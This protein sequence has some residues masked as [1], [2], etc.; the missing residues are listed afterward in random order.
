MTSFQVGSL[1]NI[2]DNMVRYYCGYIQVQAPG[3]FENRSIN[4]GFPMNPDL[5]S[6]LDGTEHVSCY[7]FRL[8]AFA[9]VS[10]GTISQGAMVMGIDPSREDSITGISKRIKVGQYLS[11]DDKGILVG[12]VLA[13]NLGAACGDTLILLGQGYHGVTAAALF[14]IRGILRFPSPEI[15]RQF[16]IMELHTAQEFYSADQIVTSAVVLLDN[17]DNMVKTKNRLTARLGT[18]YH[19]L[20]WQELQP[21]LVQLVDGKRSAGKML[22]SILFLIIGFGML[23]TVIMMVTERK[24]E[25]GV[26]IS[27]GM[28]KMRVFLVLLFEAIWVGILGVAAGLVIGYPLITQLAVHPFHLTGTMAK[29]MVDMGFE[30]VLAISNVGY[31]FLNPAVTVFILSLLVSILPAIIV[32]RMKIVNALRA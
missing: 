22:L 31:V 27:L 3:Y 26:M 19:V 12:E 21:G 18:D 11:P 7:T 4:E 17:M 15:S 14:P 13:D 5:G 23:G 28:R 16:I 6:V 10:S 8:E 20:D 25:M 1:Q 30:P 32:Y 2:V 9:L 29:T 24:R